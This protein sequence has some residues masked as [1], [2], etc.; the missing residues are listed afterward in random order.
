MIPPIPQPLP[1]AFRRIRLALARV[2]E[3]PEGSADEGYTF[4]LPL[5]PDGAIDAQHYREFKDAFRVV[6]HEEGET[7]V[8]HLVHGPGGSW[9]L[10]YDI[11][12][13][14]QEEAVFRLKDERL[15]AGEYVSIERD[16]ALH[17]FRV[18]TVERL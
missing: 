6:R 11:Q 12:G 5:A 9:T 18:V 15:V 17:P 14:H 13:A 16:G 7:S 2:P 4:I 3:H 1:E 8:G 10:N